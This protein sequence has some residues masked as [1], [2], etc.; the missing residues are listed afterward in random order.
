[1]AGELSSQQALEQAAEEWTKIVQRLGI[2][3]QKV[4]YANF[5]TGARKLGYKI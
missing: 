3:K 5:L 1:V 2:D 4:Q